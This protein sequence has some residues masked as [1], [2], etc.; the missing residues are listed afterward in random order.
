MGRYTPP[1]R[2]VDAIAYGIPVLV[3]AAGWLARRELAQRELAQRELARPKLAR[4]EVIR[5]ELAR[6]GTVP[7]GTQPVEA[8]AAVTA[9]LDIAAVPALTAD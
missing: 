1:Y 8:A 3:V 7:A 4:R 6:G 2:L 5:R 9:D